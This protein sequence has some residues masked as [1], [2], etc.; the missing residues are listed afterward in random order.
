MASPRGRGPEAER[1]VAAAIDA[2][3]ESL[4]ALKLHL[5]QELFD[6]EVWLRGKIRIDNEPEAE[7]FTRAMRIQ[8]TLE[9]YTAIH[10]ARGS[11]CALLQV[12]ETL[13]KALVEKIPTELLGPELTV[14]EGGAVVMVNG[15]FTADVRPDLFGKA[16][17]GVD[18]R[19]IR[20]CPICSKIFFARREDSVVC[21]P[22]SKC[23]KTYSKRVERKNARLRAEL[24][25]RRP[26]KPIRTKMVDAA[27][28]R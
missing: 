11:F 28:K 14:C 23:A 7:G 24:E 20:E 10:S 26:G 9:R 2:L 1:E 22:K 27:R 8:G 16:I 5:R 15:D 4:N 17:Q 18:V 13:E 3:P 19:A 6:A 12:R 25:V 21:K